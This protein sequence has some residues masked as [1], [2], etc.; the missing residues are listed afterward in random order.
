MHYFFR[1]RL[2]LASIITIT[3]C[4]HSTAQYGDFGLSEQPADTATVGNLIDFGAHNDMS[5]GYNVGDT[6][7]NFTVYDFDGNSVELYEELAG[8]KPVVLVSGSV[9]C[10]RFRKTWDTTLVTPLVE[11][12]R[13]FM[14]D[15]DENFN[16]IFIYGVEAHPTE[17]QCPSNCP[18]IIVNDTAVVQHSIYAERRW[19]MHTWLSA[20]DHYMPFNMFADNPDNAVYNAFFRRPFGLVALNCDGTV[21]IRADWVDTYFEDPNNEAEML[22]FLTSYQTCQ[23]DWQPDEEGDGDESDDSINPAS[24]LNGYNTN[25]AT[26]A[27]LEVGMDHFKVYPN[28]ANSVLTIETQSAGR[29]WYLTDMQGRSVASWTQ[30]QFQLTV[31]VDD[32][33]RGQYVL[34]GYGEELPTLHK[35]IVLQ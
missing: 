7:F 16:W 11:S 30:N 31:A 14:F 13:T 18:P 21:G 32:L 8:P 22:E 19:S 35:R 1:A 27:V 28:P 24:G 3:V 29:M 17:G 25:E 33:P 10:I 23:I 9:S 6:V 20:T 15:N 34:V 2:T 12:A 26:S 5:G 4:T